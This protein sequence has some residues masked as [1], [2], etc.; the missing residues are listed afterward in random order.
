MLRLARINAALLALAVIAWQ[1]GNAAHGRF[2]HPFLVADLL[3]AAWLLA[4][5][6][7]PERRIARAALL[8]SHAAMFG[9]FL[10]A[11]TGRMLERPPRPRHLRRRARPGPVPLPG[12]PGRRSAR[13]RVPRADD[14]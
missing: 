7:W 4:A 1:A 11:V 10:S 12:S 13:R 3:V 5:S 8:T 6:V 9:V 2:V 14:E